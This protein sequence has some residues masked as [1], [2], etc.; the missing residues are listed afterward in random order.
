[1]PYFQGTDSFSAQEGIK[2]KGN[3]IALLN[4]NKVYI[5]ICL[6][7]RVS[8]P[9]ILGICLEY[10]T[11]MPRVSDLYASNIGYLCPEYQ[12]SMP[13]TST[14]FYAS[15]TY[16]Y[17]YIYIDTVLRKRSNSQTSM[18]LTFDNGF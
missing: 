18:K 17:I 13:R 8:M 4:T 12:I 10:R 11:S 5:Y 1:M 9:W 14:K 16:I 6:E 3:I 2:S 15:N 7:Y